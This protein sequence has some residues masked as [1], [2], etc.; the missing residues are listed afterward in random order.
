MR[1]TAI[2]TTWLLV[3][4][5]MPVAT[6]NFA[7][8]AS[9]SITCKDGKTVNVSTGSDSGSC[10]VEADDLQNCMS[11]S[12]VCQYVGCTDGNKEGWGGCD[13]AGNAWCGQKGCSIKLTGIGG[14]RLLAPGLLKANP[15]FTPT[16]PPPIGTPLA[17][18]PP[19][20]PVL[21]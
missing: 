11:A 19:A 21:R 17:P 9:Q 2:L 16:P 6:S 10:S 3:W 13:G 7:D 12:G 4:I 14:N 5:L 8:A 18:K 20:G 1:T 15:G